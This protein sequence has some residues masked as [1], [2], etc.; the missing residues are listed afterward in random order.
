MRETVGHDHDD[1]QN[2]AHTVSGRSR[3]DQHYLLAPGA[4]HAHGQQAST[5]SQAAPGN[6][7]AQTGRGRQQAGGQARDPRREHDH[8]QAGHD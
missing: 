6:C 1:T 7:A 5:A 3:P 8:T 4:G 2:H